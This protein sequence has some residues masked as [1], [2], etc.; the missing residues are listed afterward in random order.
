M[1][2]IVLSLDNYQDLKYELVG[3]SDV[4]GNAEYN[5]ELSLNRINSV[6][7]VLNSLNVSNEN[8]IINNLGESQ[9]KET[10]EFE[11]YFFDRKVELVITK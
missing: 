2:S 8:I 3:Y 7:E 1:K 6:F 4:R 9:S 11:E 10:K 5:A